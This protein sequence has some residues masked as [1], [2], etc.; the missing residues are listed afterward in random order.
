MVKSRALFIGAA[1]ALFCTGT[2]AALELTEKGRQLLN[3]PLKLTLC[4]PGTAASSAC[5]A[6]SLSQLQPKIN[7]GS[8]I[9]LSP[10][11]YNDCVT[12]NKSNVTIQ[13]KGAVL[14]E[15]TCAG[16]AAFIVSGSD[17]VLKDIACEDM[18]VASLNGACV[19]MEGGS[20]TLDGVRFANS[21]NGLLG[22]N[23]DLTVINSQFQ[24]N[25]KAGRAHQIYFNSPYR[26]TVR[27]STFVGAQDEG[28]GIKTGARETVLDG[29]TIDGTGG[30]MSRNVDA[31][32]GGILTIV[33][34]TLI[35]ADSDVN[36]E[37][38]GY[39]YEAREDLAANA[40]TIENTRID[41]GKGATILAG[42]NSLATATIVFRNNKVSGNCLDIARLQGR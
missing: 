5:T 35:K 25:G 10:G 4:A 9:T 24:G 33:N 32:N 1:A 18:K 23:G 2:A 12:L 8:V 29:V 30:L 13:G 14:K 36:R 28:H 19:R 11:V 22:G 34:S 15:K 38:I 20:L 27:N 26:L 37:I 39:D 42:A 16:K 40:I 21:E 7:E 3:P 17:I 41:C 6:G 31:F